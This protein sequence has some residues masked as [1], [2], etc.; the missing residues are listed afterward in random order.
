V[1]QSVLCDDRTLTSPVL[2]T[3]R[4]GITANL[5]FRI[6]DLASSIEDMLLY[7]SETSSS[8][9]SD[10]SLRVEKDDA[11]LWCVSHCSAIYHSISR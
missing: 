5:S 10:T 3:L 2:S 7:A 8:D 9:K 1:F 11:L 6:M 4:T